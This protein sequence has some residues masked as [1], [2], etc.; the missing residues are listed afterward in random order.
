MERFVKPLIYHTEVV[1]GS[2]TVKRVRLLHYSFF[3]AFLSMIQCTMHNVKAVSYKGYEVWFFFFTSW[4]AK[5]YFIL[6][7]ETQP[8]KCYPSPLQK[9]N[10]FTSSL[11]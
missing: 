7:G 3:F 2:F 11:I 10:S 9:R 1:T 5:Q 8:A 4:K 6:S